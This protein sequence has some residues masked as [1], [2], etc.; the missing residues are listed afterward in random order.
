MSKNEDK[1]LAKIYSEAIE[2]AETGETIPIEIESA[3]DL[4]SML[5]NEAIH[6]Q[7][8]IEGEIRHFQTVDDAV[9]H[10]KDATSFEVDGDDLRTNLRLLD[11]DEVWQLRE[12]CYVKRL[13]NDGSVVVMTGLVYAT[14]NEV[15]TYLV[16]DLS[17]DNFTI[18]HEGE[19]VVV[20]INGETTIL[21]KSSFKIVVVE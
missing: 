15:H 16:A 2:K 3:E 17:K 13:K 7:T 19:T 8:N 11:A 4:F 20:T 5:K 1:E 21:E 14:F 12:D 18:L 10:I 6:L 9:D